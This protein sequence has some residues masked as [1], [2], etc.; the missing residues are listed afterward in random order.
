MHSA[1]RN[2][3]GSVSEAWRALFVQ[4]TAAFNR[5][6]HEPPSIRRLLETGRDGHRATE[7][8]AANAQILHVALAAWLKDWFI[9]SLNPGGL[10]GGMA[11]HTGYRLPDLAPLRPP[12]A[13][14]QL[15]ITTLR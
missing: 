12:E 1:S 2:G 10:D 3:A 15:T 6:S 11:C 7:I 4:H 9:I 13:T 8:C 14:A 5:K